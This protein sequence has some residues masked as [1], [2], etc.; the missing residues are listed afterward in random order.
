MFLLLIVVWIPPLIVL[1]PHC[2]LLA[3]CCGRLPPTACPPT[4]ALTCPK[5]MSCWRKTTEWTD[6]RAAPRRSMSSWRPVSSKTYPEYDWR[7]SISFEGLYILIICLSVRLE[8]ESF[9]T[10][11]FCWNTPSL[12]NHVPGVQ[13]LWWSVLLS[14]VSKAPWLVGVKM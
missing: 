13:Y 5:C 7:H 12:W 3:C 14:S 4:P 11:I 1:C 9:R 6:Q 8:V 10:S 2:Q